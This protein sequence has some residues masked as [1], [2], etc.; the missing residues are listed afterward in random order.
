MQQVKDQHA[1]EAPPPQSM[2]GMAT[3]V[4]GDSSSDSSLNKVQENEGMV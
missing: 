1:P 4:G 2:E 3:S